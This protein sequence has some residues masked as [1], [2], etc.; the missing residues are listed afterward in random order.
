MRR[1]ASR[2][3][4]VTALR[5]RSAAVAPSPR[6]PPSG[7][8]ARRSSARTWSRSSAA[9]SS[10]PTSCG[11]PGVGQLLVEFGQ[12]T[13]VRRQRRPVQGRRRRRRRSGRGYRRARGRARRRPAGP[14]ST[15]RSCSPLASRSRADPPLVRDE[16]ELAVAAAGRPVAR[17]PGA[18][19]RVSGCGQP[20][21]RRV[22]LGQPGAGAER[23]VDVGGPRPAR[24]GPR[25]LDPARPGAARP[26]ARGRR[27]SDTSAPLTAHVWA[28]GSRSLQ[29]LR[30]EWTIVQRDRRGDQLAHEHRPQVRP[31]AAPP[32]AG[33]ARCPARAGPRPGRRRGPGS[34]PPRRA[35]A[36]APRP[37]SGPPRRPCPA[38]RPRPRG[39]GPA[40]AAATCARCRCR[41][42]R[43]A[44]PARGRLV[45]EPSAALEVAVE[46]RERGLPGP[47][48]VVVARLAQPLG[49]VDVLGQGRPERRVAP[50]PAGRWRSAAA[51]A[52]AAPDRRPGRRAG[53]S[54]RRSRPAGRG[55]R[56]PHGVVLGQQAARP[57]WPGRRG[58]GRSPRPAR[59]AAAAR[60]RSGA[61][62]A[63]AGG[64]AR[65]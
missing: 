35:R 55:A 36:P 18:G 44:R 32:R 50:A 19:P 8:V 25:R 13:P 14:I 59:P 5:A 9:R 11:G 42:R 39:P 63:A 30:T 40:P 43:P 23:G 3:R 7:R 49:H 53:R 46:Q 47:Q 38:A 2:I 48:Q 51:P 6:T 61:P 28:Y 27:R 20:V 10:R 58:G 21:P 22:G 29:Q 31:V 16:P 15:A 65:R 33:P 52:R 64:P 4:P 62:S 12:S 1:T 60:G 45:A 37:T 54:R 34:R 24:S 41:C 56:R 57:G 17:G 26:G